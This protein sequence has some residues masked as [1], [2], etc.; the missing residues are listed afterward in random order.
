LN[1]RVPLPVNMVAQY[2]SFDHP[3]DETFERLLLHKTERT[4]IEI[5]EDHIL[6]CDFCLTRVQNLQGQIIATKL[7]IRKMKRKQ[8]ARTATRTPLSRLNHL[9]LR[10]LLL[11]AV[12]AVFVAKLIFVPPPVPENAAIAEVNLSAY[13]SSGAVVLPQGRPVHMTLDA[14]DLPETP[15]LVQ[16]V[17]PFGSEI[18]RGDAAVLQEKAEIL[19]PPFTSRG[20]YLLRLYA[21]AARDKKGEILREYAFNVK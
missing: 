7:A 11:T 18:W 14:A 15:V 8:A 20:L 12:S 16:V 6:A 4:E 17:N 2:S 13:R 10:A 5:L 1:E 9:T 21:P 3:P 19:F